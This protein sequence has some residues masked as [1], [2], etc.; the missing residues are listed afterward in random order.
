MPSNHHIRQIKSKLSILGV[1]SSVY[2]WKQKPFTDR[3]GTEWKGAQIDMLI[4]R[5]DDVINICEMKYSIDE[6]AITEEYERKLRQRAAL[7]QHV[8]KT[9]KA[10]QHTFITT[11]GV[12]KNLYSG[13][14]QSE[15]TV[16]DL[17][18]E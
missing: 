5:R 6:Y 15:V 16:D 18:L 10:L 3:D 1:L 7:F 13:I 14:V 17:F 12:R 11:Y 2:S 8:T 4:D 9:K